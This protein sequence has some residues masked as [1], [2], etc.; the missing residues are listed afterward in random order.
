MVDASREIDTNAY[1]HSSNVA[2]LI[3]AHLWWGVREKKLK[4]EEREDMVVF[5]T[6]RV[7]RVFTTPSFCDGSALHGPSVP[8]AI[9]WC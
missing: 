2:T 6:K 3:L 5:D 9:C 4:L 1:A 7:K 8:A